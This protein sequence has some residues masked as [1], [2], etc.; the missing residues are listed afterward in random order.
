MVLTCAHTDIE[1]QRDRAYVKCIEMANHSDNHIFTNGIFKMDRATS[2]D[3]GAL[4][5]TFSG[6][7]DFLLYMIIQFL[8]L[9]EISGL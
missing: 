3:F 8:Q 4:H 5:K 9:V 2:G 6:R 1:C 7:S